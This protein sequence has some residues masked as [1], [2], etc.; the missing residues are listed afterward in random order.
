MSDDVPP[1]DYRHVVE[2]PEA[3]TLRPIGVVRSIFTERHGTPRQA[4]LSGN[5][6]AAADAPGRVELDPDQIPPEALQDLDGFDFIWLVTYL[7]LNTDR[8]AARV[9]PPRGGGR[10]GVFSTRAPH[11]PNNLGLSAVRLVSVEGLTLHLAGV[12]LIDGTPVLDIK[13]YVHFADA[14]PDA[15]AGW[16]DAMGG[17]PGVG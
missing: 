3:V 5:R 1:R 4:G 16:V 6:G 8:W 17:R 13:P 15:R 14:F 7:H 2:F 9:R 12:D 11:R 10:R